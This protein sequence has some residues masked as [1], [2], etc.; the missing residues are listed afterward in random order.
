MKKLLLIFNFIFVILFLSSCKIIN[1]T[2]TTN[3]E[4]INNSFGTWWWD[5]NLDIDTYLEFAKEYNINE[6][7]FCDYSFKNN[8][9]ILLP[10]AYNYNIKVY[11]LAGEKEWLN[12]RKGLDNLINNYI[13][14]QNNSEYKLS[15]IHLD[16]E[17]HQF[18]DFKNDRYNYLY[19]LIDL[20]KTNKELY[21]D[22]NF[23]YDI[24]FWLDDEIEY[25]SITKSAYRH[26]IDY[27]TRTFIMSYRD[28]KEEMIDVSKDEIEYAKDNN[29]ILYLSAET[30]S[31]EGDNVSYLE[32]GKNYMLDELNKLRDLIPNS[33]GIAI[34]N[35][36][37]FMEL[38]D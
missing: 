12:D 21:K 4:N 7:Y 2:K 5:K 3:E 6:I 11:L 26:I 17:P 34:H 32:E 24:P 31:T 23:D 1:N 35:I 8:L 16:I 14:F 28:T 20:V 10:K 33:F 25:N 15:G 36:K 38:K 13:E 37:S 19:K 22:I 30:Y 27:S 9:S 18:S 29:K